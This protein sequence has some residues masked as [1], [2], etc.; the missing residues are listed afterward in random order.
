MDVFNRGQAINLVNRFWTIDPITEIATLANPS[1]VTF[2]I[3]NPNDTTVIYTFGI[4][5]NVSN[6]DTGIFVCSLDPQL[7][8]GTYR[9]RATGDGAVQAASEDYFDVIESGVLPP[10]QPTTAVVGPCSS[11]INGDDVANFGPPIDGIGS[12]TWLLDDV[13]YNAS[14]LLYELSGRQFPGVC[15]RTVRP[16][17]DPCTCFK[18]SPSLGVGP[19]AWTWMGGWG[20]GGWGWRNE[21]GDTAGCGTLS[22]V[23][24]AGYPVREITEVKIDGAV[25]NAVDSSGNP[26]YRLD[27]RTR[28]LRMND[29]GPPEQDRFWPACQDMALNDDETGTFSIT[30]TWGA[31]VPSLGRE[32][33]AQLARELWF[34]INGKNCQLPNKATRVVRAGITIDRITPLAETL[35]MGATGLILVDAFIALVNPA[36]MTR[37]PAVWSPD[38]QRYARSAG[39]DNA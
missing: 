28:L 10:A 25:L 33:A 26:N 19:W 17:A 24:L 3:Y 21:C 22:Y 29:P 32:A 2:E 1:T 11:W 14:H 5:L 6:P 23:N 27:G 39:Q 30:Y 35:R 4:D 15:T 13:A 37:R 12:D 8:V 38:R 34:A 18:F 7:P 31:D 20:V 36:K 16:C 9:Y